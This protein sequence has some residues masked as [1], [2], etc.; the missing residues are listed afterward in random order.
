MSVAGMGFGTVRL[1]GPGVWGPPPD[2]SASR[3]LLQSVVEQGVDLI[4]TSNSYGPHLVENLIAE[5]LWPYPDHVVIATKGGLVPSGPGRFERDGRPDSLRRSCEGSL[6]RLRL[7]HIDLYQL[8][9]VD[10]NVPIEDSVGAL[11]DLQNMGLIRHIGLSNVSVEQLTRAEMVAP[12]V[13]VQNCY[14]V[15]DRLYDDLVSA[16]EKNAM[17]FFPWFPLAR[18]H[19]SE[20][21]SV[22]RR[23][24]TRKEAT[25]AQVALAW[26]LHRSPAI[27]PI[28]GTND[29]AHFESNY[30]AVDLKLD[31]E[32]LI[33]LDHID[34]ATPPL[35][36]DPSR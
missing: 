7:D 13:S 30:A 25:T 18:G 29:A 32:D 5:A 10:P 31:L 28:P 22:L 14:N 11:A 34:L 26:L 19:L 6:R 27:L 16:C 33:E 9:A 4:D 35:V 24:A 2:P 3:E 23:I 21:G 8:H 1:T 36:D 17:V 15:V 20:Q 12:I